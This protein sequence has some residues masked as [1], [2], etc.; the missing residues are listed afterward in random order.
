MGQNTGIVIID[1]ITCPPTII[2]RTAGNSC[3]SKLTVSEQPEEGDKKA[4]KL[5][6][7]LLK[8]P[9]DVPDYI[10][11]HELC[12]VKINSH[13]HHYWDLVRKYMPSYQE[14]IDW[15]NANI[16]SILV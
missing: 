3:Y 2:L 1:A 8:A 11:L 16:T 10:I 4:I 9:D 5:N 13:S 14:K 6:V 12:H 7:N 15:L